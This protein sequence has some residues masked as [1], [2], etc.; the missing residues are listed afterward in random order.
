MSACEP[1]EPGSLAGALR[2]FSFFSFPFSFS[3]LLLFYFLS[4]FA[5]QLTFSKKKKKKKKRLILQLYDAHLSPDG[6][7]VSYSGI[8][9]D[10][11]FV[12]YVPSTSPFLSPVLVSFPLISYSSLPL[13]F[14]KKKKVQ[15]LC[16]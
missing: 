4:S 5:F 1:M 2:K 14:L 15:N 16:C 7:K 8:K 13:L 10:P 3:L 6:L 9:N 11:L 12:T